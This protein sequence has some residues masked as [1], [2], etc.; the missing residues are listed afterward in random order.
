MDLALEVDLVE[1]D[2]QYLSVALPES[3]DDYNE[4]R[5]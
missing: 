4:Q 3:Y 1:K 2:K 5:A